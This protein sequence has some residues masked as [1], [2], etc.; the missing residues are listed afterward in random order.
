MGSEGLSPENGETPHGLDGPDTAKN[1]EDVSAA[2]AAW[3]W[4]ALRFCD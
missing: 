1:V 2:V 4:C 3:H